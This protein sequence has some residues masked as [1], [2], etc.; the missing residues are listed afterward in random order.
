VKKPDVI[1][2]PRQPIRTIYTRIDFDFLL[3]KWV[4]S[5]LIVDRYPGPEWSFEEIRSQEASA[6]QMPPHCLD[7]AQEAVALV[8]VIHWVASS[9]GLAI[10]HSGLPLTEDGTGT[11]S[12]GKDPDAGD[13]AWNATNTPPK[14]SG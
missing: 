1:E 6:A 13:E 14:T 8:G 5:V 2:K 12:V 3:S 9:V 11:S 4:V 10:S 7:R